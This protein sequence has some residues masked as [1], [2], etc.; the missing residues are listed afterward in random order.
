M[1]R[2]LRVALGLSG[3]GHLIH[4]AEEFGLGLLFLAQSV[5]PLAIT[6]AFLRTARR[7]TRRS[8]DL[9]GIW[10]LI[11]VVVGG[12]SVFPWPFLP[13]VP[14]QTVGHYAAHLVYALLQLPLLVLVRRLRGRRSGPGGAAWA[15]P[16]APRS[17]D[18]AVALSRVGREP[19]TSRRR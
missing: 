1:T 4:N 13:F 18:V 6:A 11:V 19:R 5:V 8:L 7:P 17:S 3:L 16:H 12:G 15:C 10:G 9:L 14:A 2:S